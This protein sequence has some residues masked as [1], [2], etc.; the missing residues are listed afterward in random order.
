MKTMYIASISGY[1]GHIKKIEVERESDSYVWINGRRTA[2]KTNYDAILDTI[3][4]AKKY[5]LSKVENKIQMAEYRLKEVQK[6]KEKLLESFKTFT[7]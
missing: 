2:K 6:E 5:L 4:D 1:N 3:D 7:E